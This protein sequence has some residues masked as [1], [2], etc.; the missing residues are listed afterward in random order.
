MGEEKT[1]GSNGQ[2]EKS[3]KISKTKGPQRGEVA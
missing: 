2:L 3:T 1:S